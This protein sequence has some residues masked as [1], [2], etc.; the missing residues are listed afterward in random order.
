MIYMQRRRRKDWM[1]RLVSVPKGFLSYGVLRLLRCTPMSGSELMEEIERRT[2]WRPS[3]GSIYPLLAKLEGRKFIKKVKSEEAG[4]K[5]FMLTEKGKERLKEYDM[6]NEIFRRKFHTIRRMW[7]K[8]YKE[9]DEDLYQSNVRLF[10]SIERI[11]RYLKKK[12]AKEA[13]R[14]VRLILLKAADEIENL[15]KSLEMEDL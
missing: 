10:E 2:G 7:L 12:E 1:R 4:L 11:N 15:R 9:M 13:A 5:R 3:P 14:K 8:I 6:M